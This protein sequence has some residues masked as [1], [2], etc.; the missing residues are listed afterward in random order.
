MCIG[1]RIPESFRGGKKL[2]LYILAS[3]FPMDLRI[4]CTG[5]SLNIMDTARELIGAKKKN[6]SHGNL[7]LW[8]LILIS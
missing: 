4:L 1:G 7:L 8:L 2:G 5:Y 6:E 3:S